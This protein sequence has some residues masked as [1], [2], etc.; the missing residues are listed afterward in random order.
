MSMGIADIIFLCCLALAGIIGFKRGGIRQIAIFLAIYLG[1]TLSILYYNDFSAW[2]ESR[3]TI[4]HKWSPVL[5]FLLIFAG[6]ALVLTIAGNLLAKLM[7][8]SLL[9][10][11][12]R[13]AGVIMGAGIFAMVMS[14]TVYF[15]N[16][17]NEQFALVPQSRLSAS[18]FYE[19]LLSFSKSVFPFLKSLF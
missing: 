3:I 19:P 16:A 17:A 18:I 9:G 7:K 10:W 8:I 2:I 12:D 13:L 5:A 15:F 11:L 6:S 14:V 4:S 1:I